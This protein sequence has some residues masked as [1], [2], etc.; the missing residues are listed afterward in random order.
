MNLQ[1]QLHKLNLLVYQTQ[2]VCVDLQDIEKH[3][4]PQEHSH[5]DQ[6]HSYVV[7]YTK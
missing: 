1:W 4:N 2:S 5:Y 3:K 6:I 7:E